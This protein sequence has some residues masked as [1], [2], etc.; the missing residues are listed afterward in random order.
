ME[1]LKSLKLDFWWKVVLWIGVA[2]CAISLIFE[3][4]IV[5]PKHLFGFGIGLV[6]IGVSIFAALKKMVI[7]DL[8]GYWSIPVIKH[9]ICSR[10]FLIIGIILSLLFGILLIINLI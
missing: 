5:S 7:W 1:I 2:L 8:Q 6:I 4:K 9:N 10:I 3:I